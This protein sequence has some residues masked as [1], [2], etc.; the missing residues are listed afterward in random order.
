MQFLLS[1]QEGLIGLLIKD[2]TPEDSTDNIIPHSLN[3]HKHTCTEGSMI[4]VVIGLDKVTSGVF[5]IPI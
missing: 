4:I 5:S 2:N 3:L 1:V